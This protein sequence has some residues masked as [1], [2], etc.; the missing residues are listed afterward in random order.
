MN[1]PIMTGSF[2]AM[3]GAIVALVYGLSS[4]FRRKSKG[5][6]FQIMVLGVGAFALGRF[7]EVLCFT[8]QGILPERAHL[9]YMGTV[10]M[11]IFFLTASRGSMDDLLDDRREE[12]RKYRR[13]A[14]IA[15]VCM[16]AVTACAILIG[17]KHL[18]QKVI[19][20]LAGSVMMF[21]VYYECKH[22]MLPDEGLHFVENIRWTNL[23][24]IVLNF[25]ALGMLYTQMMRIQTVYLLLSVFSV[26]AAIVLIVT[27]E[28]G[29]RAW[30]R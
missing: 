1:N 13:S 15:P 5:L 17:D 7:Y 9:G 20:A 6:F 26:I 11:A 24:A 25:S 10:D 29:V 3:V 19:L 30:L 14:L 27:T 28:K 2:I 16:A 8:T 12:F 18:G 4:I 22:L 21:S 23:A